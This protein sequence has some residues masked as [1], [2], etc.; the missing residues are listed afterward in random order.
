VFYLEIKLL[1]G[2]AESEAGQ[3]E[4]IRVVLP[5]VLR[6]MRI[7]RA[8]TQSELS[9]SLKIGGRSQITRS[10][11]SRFECGHVTPPLR[12]VLLLAAKLG[13]DQLVLRIRDPR[14]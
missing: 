8:L 6:D 9:R 3:S 14:L 4:M 5:G 13:V 7:R 12:T 11:L 1:H 10:Q 2:I